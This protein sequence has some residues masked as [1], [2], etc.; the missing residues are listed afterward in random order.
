MKILAADEMEGRETG[1]PGLRKAQEYVVEQ[2]KRAGWNPWAHVGTT[3]R[4]S[5]FRARS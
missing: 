4:C 1:S 2:L 5:L 3:S